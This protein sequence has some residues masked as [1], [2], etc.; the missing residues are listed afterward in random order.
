MVGVKQADDTSLLACV[1]QSYEK[2]PAGLEITTAFRKLGGWDS[3]AAVLLVARLHAEFGVTVSAGE[4]A[5]C[6]T[7]QDLL[8]MTLKKTGVQA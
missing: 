2:A 3:L 8:A 1:S 6:E 4:L 7:V 5:E